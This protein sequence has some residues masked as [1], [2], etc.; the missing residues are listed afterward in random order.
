MGSFAGMAIRR[1]TGCRFT[2][3]GNS[4]GDRA[5]GRTRL[6]GMATEAWPVAGEGGRRARPVAS[7][8]R[9][10]LQRREAGPQVDPA[11]LQGMGS[12]PRRRTLAARPAARYAQGDKSCAGRTHDC[13]PRSSRRDIPQDRRR[14]RRHGSHRRRTGP[15]PG[16]RHHRRQRIALPFGRRAGLQRR[17]LQHPVHP[18][19][20]GTVHGLLVALPGARPRAPAPHR[21]LLRE[22]SHRGR[23]VLGLARGDL[24]RPAHAA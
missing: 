15:G 20:P 11:C 9:L 8:G 14:T 19:R 18:D 23:H 10:L 12:R 4:V 7:H 17:R 1:R 24:Y 13:R 16:A 5:R 22:P 6:P 21:H 3:A 2:L